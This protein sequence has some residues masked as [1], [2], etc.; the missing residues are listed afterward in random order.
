MIQNQKGGLM[1]AD[2]LDSLLQFPVKV[3]SNASDPLIEKVT[4][5][6]EKHFKE[7]VFVFGASLL[8]INQPKLALIG[9]IAGLALPISK[10]PSDVEGIDDEDKPVRQR[11]AAQVLLGSGFSLMTSAFPYS[12]FVQIGVMIGSIGIGI[13]SKRYYSMVVKNTD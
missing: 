13:V 2:I 7:I 8:G 10:L 3:L 9:T 4:Y 12:Y 6:I 11:F 1:K 5:F